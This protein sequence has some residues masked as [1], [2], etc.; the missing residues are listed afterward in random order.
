MAEDPYAV[1]GVGREASQD[2]I[3]RHYRAL[4]KELHPDLNPDK[5]EVAERFK[6]I[7]A[8]YDL[9]SDP[10]KRARY[11]K[12]EIDASGQERPQPSY[13]DFADDPQATRFYTR[14][15][16]GDADSLHDLFE[17]LFGDAAARG[18]QG[19]SF[20]MRARGADVSYTL[21]VDFLDAA[22]GARKRVTVGDGHVI[23]LTLP[24]G[25][26]DRQTLRL[27]GQGMPGFEGG[28]PG[29]AYVEVRV[30]PHA[31]FERKDSN[32][33]VELPVSLAEAVLGGRIE[34]PTIDGA[35]S[36][37]VPKG[38]NSGTTL[39]LKGRG[40][41][42]PKGG[43]RGD[44]YVRLRVVLPKSADPELEELVRRWAASHP[45]DPRAELAGRS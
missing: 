44:Q 9:L 14:E 30:Q 15:G 42:D 24:A 33:H 19:R 1:I 23:D 13:R 43:Q 7:T 28:T 25:V 11:D 20:R 2:E 21:P 29:D 40:I 12:G 34:V 17:G 10:D 8:A 18:Q 41:L 22:K 39:R 16:F 32:V 36:M 45:Y 31:L 27:K 4:A 38:S 26:R 37:T 5:P 6:L 3:K 35:V